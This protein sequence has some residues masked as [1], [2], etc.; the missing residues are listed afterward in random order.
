MIDNTLV[1]IRQIALAVGLSDYFP[2][3]YSEQQI[4]ELRQAIISGHREG[5]WAIVN[6][7]EREK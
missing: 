1:D 3:A 4:E 5:R 2:D 7:E 6:F